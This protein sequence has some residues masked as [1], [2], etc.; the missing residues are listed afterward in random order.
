MNVLLLAVAIPIAF[1]AA[2]GLTTL[3]MWRMPG[4]P[5]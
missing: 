4:G 3:L 5:R 1:L 2:A